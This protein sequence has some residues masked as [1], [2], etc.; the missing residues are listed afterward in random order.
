MQVYISNS[1]VG[2][3]TVYESDSFNA[4]WAMFQAASK[5]NWKGR[6]VNQTC[7]FTIADKESA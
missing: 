3:T 4:C 7:Y 2:Q 6:E 5:E 1:V